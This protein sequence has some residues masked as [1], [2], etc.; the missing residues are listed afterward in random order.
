MDKEIEEAPVPASVE[1][2]PPIYRYESIASTNTEA[3]RLA[4][5]GAPHH[6]VLLAEYQSA[7]R[8]QFER[9][10]VMPRGEGVL[11]TMVFREMP[12][13][14][15]FTTLTLQVARAMAELLGKTGG[16]EVSIKEPNDL[17]VG[18]KKLA[19]ILSEAR[20]RGDK[21]LY[22]VVGI[23]VNVNV[24]EFPEELCEIACSLALESGKRFDVAAVEEAM[25]ERLKG[26]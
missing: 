9:R 3:L 15:E 4:E 12:P 10:W 5:Q 11:M 26:L 19:G 18:S 1:G 25:I 14:V 23:G 21:M 13:G 16:I 20:W 7:G 6:T 17:M 24:S 8:G 22:A 2:D